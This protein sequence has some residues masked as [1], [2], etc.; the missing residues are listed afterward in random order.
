M[1]TKKVDDN[2]SSAQ[3]A[4]REM[5]EHYEYVDPTYVSH[6]LIN[7][8]STI[9][10]VSAL[11]VMVFDP[12]DLLFVGK[13]VFLIAFSVI[14]N[15]L[16]KKAIRGGEKKGTTLFLF[17]YIELFRKIIMSYTLSISGTAIFLSTSIEENTDIISTLNAEELAVVSSIADSLT[18][19]SKALLPKSIFALYV[20][21][22]IGMGI[23]ATP[24]LLHAM[25]SNIGP[26]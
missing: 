19:L 6:Y 10:L 9:A 4:I 14:S 18:I 13:L 25:K 17:E 23:W 2:I 11:H 7:I 24:T 1:E 5:T 22:T 3:E 16:C 8:V 26:I 21:F 20:L 15:H 12:K